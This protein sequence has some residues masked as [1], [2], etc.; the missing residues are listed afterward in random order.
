MKNISPSIILLQTSK[1]E[2]Q[3]KICSNNKIKTLRFAC[4][5][6]EMNN[7]IQRATSSIPLHENKFIAFHK[8][9]QTCKLIE[10]KQKTE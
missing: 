10:M 1:R 9:A 8:M 3:Q 4:K 5:T 7:K 2:K 6:L